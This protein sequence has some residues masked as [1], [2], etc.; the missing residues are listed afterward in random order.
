RP[1]HRPDGSPAGAA[2]RPFR[3]RPGGPGRREPEAPRLPPRPAA[4]LLPVAPPARPRTG[5]PGAPTPP[6]VAGPG[7]RP[8]G[9]GGAAP[10]RRVG[11]AAGRP[12][13][14]ERHEPQPGAHPG[15]AAA[16][17]PRC[18]RPVGLDRPRDA[19]DALP[20]RALVR[21]DRRGA[22]PRARGGQDAAPAR[23][24]APPGPALGRG[25]ESRTMTDADDVDGRTM[26]GRSEQSLADRVAELA[27]RLGGGEAP[28]PENPA[29][30]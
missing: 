4:P 22:R 24:P 29:R 8:R 5:H 21:R 3:H 18:A 1:G 15:R 16:A 28:Y 10:P 2:D 30:G 12:P 7:R 25:W 26:A 17:T 19:R 27:E 13:G 6:S 20:G 14:G 11:L 9:A 23:P